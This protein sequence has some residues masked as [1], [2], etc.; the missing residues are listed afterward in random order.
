MTTDDRHAA[1]ARR[2]LLVAAAALPAAGCATRARPVSREAA[3]AEVRAA[4]TGFA[5]TMARRDAAAFAGFVADDAVFVNG[6]RPLRGKAAVVEFWSRFFAGPTAP[7]AW[8]PEIVE[9]TGDGAL[10]YSEGPV[11]SPNLPMRKM[12]DAGTGGQRGLSG[13]RARRPVAEPRR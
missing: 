10:G 11:T 9:V 1:H 13:Q 5:G 3:A 4:E 8:A 12:V 6:G 7:F 2:S